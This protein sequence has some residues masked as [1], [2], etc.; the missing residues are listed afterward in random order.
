[1]AVYLYTTQMTDTDIFC[2]NTPARSLDTLVGVALGNGPEQKCHTS[3]HLQNSTY[4]SQ[5]FNLKS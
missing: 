3:S 2:Q 4:K 5:K 1:M